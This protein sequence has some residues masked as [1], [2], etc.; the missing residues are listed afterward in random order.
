M[1]GPATALGAPTDERGGV[2]SPFVYCAAAGPVEPRVRWVLTSKET[3]KKR[4]F[5]WTGS[6]PSVALPRVPVGRYIS[7]TVAHCRDVTATRRQKLEVV[8]KTPETTISRAEFKAIED[9]LTRGEVK[10]IVGYGGEGAG[11]W[12]NHRARTY[13]RMAFWRWSLV[14]FTD[15]LVTDKEWD[16]PH[17]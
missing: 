5:R 10:A 11:H 1:I 17:G 3:G 14:V 4:T 8:Q 9:G 16:V 6:F 13:D 15:G 2:I 12:G 7:Y